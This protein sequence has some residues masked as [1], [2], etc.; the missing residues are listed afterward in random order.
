MRPYASA[1]VILGALPAL[2]AAQRADSTR[3]DTTRADSLPPVV[4]TA[5]RVPLAAGSVPASVS[6]VAGAELRRQGVTRL[7]D[8]LQELPGVSVVRSGSFGGT[9]SLFMRG[10]DSRYVKVLVDG[11][12]VNDPGGAVDLSTLTTD[13]VDRIEVVRGPASVLYGADAVAGVIQIFTRR[14]AGPAHGT[15]SA[16]GGSY[17]SADVGAA[18]LGTLGAGASYSLDLAHHETKGI[19]A[20]NNAY[21]DNVA[22]GS[23]SLAPDSLTSVRLTL[24]YTDYAYHYPTNGSGQP[25]D[26][27]AVEAN[28]VTTLGIAASRRLSSHVTAALSLASNETSGGTTQRPDALDSTTYFSID[29]VRRRSAD[30]RANVLLGAP[31][32]LTVGGQVEREDQRSQSSYD[33]YGFASNAVFGAARANRALYAQLLA[34]PVDPV[35]VTA[36]AR[37]DRNER[38]GSFGTWRVGASWRVVGATRLRASAG[39]GFR[40][41]TFFENYSTSFTTGNPDLRP[42]QSR[43]W[44]AG[45]EQGLLAD[46]VTV[47]ATWFA[48]Q[49]R[50]MIDYTT[51]TSA[52][53]ASYCNVARARANG[54][55][56]EATA[57]LLDGLTV[58][59]NLTHL[60]TRVL[61]PGF[62]TSSAGLYLRGQQ[63]VRRPRTTWNAGL[64]YARSRGSVD[65]RV[66]HEGERMDRDYSGWPAKPV[67]LAPYTLTAMG[68][69]LVVRPPA[70]GQLGATLTLRVENAF[71]VKYTSVYGFLTPGRTV[72]AGG[73]VAF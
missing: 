10:G 55:E 58:D 24:R 20:F 3:A 26:S 17:G 14:G 16:R 44:E 22:S 53:G 31:A 57:R 18:A 4:V 67:V 40:E 49:F 61:D 30:A 64:V 69:E 46:R 33:A 5:T 42:E 47:G 9:T 50:N 13:N 2:A 71:D 72:L 7:A 15:I 29:R 51:S 43:S 54:Q 34:T 8:A 73:R 48:Q 52:C 1:L 59:G 36:G 28:D 60:D 62:D 19:Y 68:A 39:T 65:L 38:F 32:T 25:V 11:V 21:R 63:L 12:P 6:V 41:P 70:P 45:V 23:F 27:D 66:T 56:L 35:T 37:N